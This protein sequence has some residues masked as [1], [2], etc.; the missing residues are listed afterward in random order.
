MCFVHKNKHTNN[1]NDNRLDKNEERC[2]ETVMTNFHSL[3]IFANGN[4]RIQ[5]QCLLPL[6][7]TR[8]RE[9]HRCQM[10]SLKIIALLSKLAFVVL[11]CLVC[12]WCLCPPPSTSA[13]FFYWLYSSTFTEH[14]YVC[15]FFSSSL[16]YEFNSMPCH[17]RRL[18]R[19][20]RNR[21]RISFHLA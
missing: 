20:A 2:V 14:V 12:F 21:N 10:Q 6:S 3:G 16:S 7:R 18:L 19:C 8:Q 13:T 5:S 4:V 17:A 11:S 9:I 1:L 15:A